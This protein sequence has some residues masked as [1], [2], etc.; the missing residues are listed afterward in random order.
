MYLLLSILVGVYSFFFLI[1]SAF[2][3]RKDQYGYSGV[4]TSPNKYDFITVIIPVRNEAENI[5]HL[6]HDLNR[7]H[8]EKQQFE[9]LVVDDSSEDRTVGIIQDQRVKMKFDLSLIQ[10]RIPDKDTKSH[11]KKAIEQGVAK[12]RG[13]LLILTDGD[14]RV[15]PLWLS[16]VLDHFNSFDT[17]LLSGPVTLMGE[18]G[19]FQDW[20]TIEFASLVG[21]G[22]ASLKAGFPNMCNAANL[23]F[24]KEA[25]LRV[26]GYEEFHHIPTGDDA[27]LMQ[28]IAS[29]FPGKVRFIKNKHS[30]VHTHPQEN[31]NSF[32]HQR[33]RW[34]SKWSYHADFRVKFL[35]IS[36]CTFQSFQPSQKQQHRMDRLAPKAKTLM[37]LMAFL[38]SSLSLSK[39]QSPP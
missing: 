19:L 1:L 23:A 8:L 5:V 7:Q 29:K 6:L 16:T 14:C 24:T 9:V 32:Y 18:R 39:I 4:K 2:W 30:I 28:K 17:H 33:K 11:K 37:G 27:F 10:L 34:A 21:T 35:A 25:F 20:Q 26:N 12:A 31:L 36:I 38:K 13:D 3:W 22:G 15:R